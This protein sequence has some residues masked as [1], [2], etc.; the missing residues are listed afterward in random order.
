LFFL[1]KFSGSGGGGGAAGMAVV[2]ALVLFLLVVFASFLVFLKGFILSKT[3]LGEGGGGGGVPSFGGS[4]ALAMVIA[5]HNPN[6]NGI[7]TRY[8]NKPRLLFF[9]VFIYRFCL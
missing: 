1:N 8:R 9:T 6:P 2:L 7:A 3:S 4:C 5:K